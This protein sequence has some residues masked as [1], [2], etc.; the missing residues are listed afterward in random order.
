M[1]T[2]FLILALSLL[3]GTS[4]QAHDAKLHKAPMLSGV[5][6]SLQNDK[7]SIKTDKGEVLIALM[8]ETK[9]EA[10]MDGKKAERANL[11]VGQELMVMGHKLEDGEFAA[12]EVIIHEKTDSHDHRSMN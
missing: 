3:I 6:T 1:R 8:P 5:I 4:A 9:Y 10:G 11:K 12:A 2:P 7:V